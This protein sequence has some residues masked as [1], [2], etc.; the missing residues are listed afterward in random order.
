[1]ADM[2]TLHLDD[3]EVQRGIRLFA[4]DK[5]KRVMANALNRTAHDVL[6]ELKAHASTIF[7]FAGTQTEQFLAGRGSFG[8]DPPGAT[9]DK[10]EVTVR[11]REKSGKILEE[12][13]EGAR[14]YGQQHERLTFGEQLAVPA[15]KQ[16]RIRTTRG[17]VPKPLLP[18]ELLKRPD[19]R[20]YRAGRYIFSRASAKAESALRFVL[21]DQAKL[22]P[23]FD[24]FGTVERTARAVFIQKAKEE[25]GKMRLRG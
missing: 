18:S 3:R 23:V 12:H 7:E 5:V 11:P 25:F 22:K 1:M 13:A 9:P 8:F 16:G 6:D 2:I 20:G 4:D 15:G 24:F 10:L 19:G 21:V 17:R 14:I